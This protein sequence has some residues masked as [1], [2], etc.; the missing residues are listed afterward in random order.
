MCEA[1][2][3]ARHMPEIVGYIHC[4]KRA[5]QDQAIS[6]QSILSL[7]LKQGHDSAQYGSGCKPLVLA[8]HKCIG[9]QTPAASNLGTC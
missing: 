6:T 8:G 4:S 7:G 1:L 9:E 5:S 2:A 3:L